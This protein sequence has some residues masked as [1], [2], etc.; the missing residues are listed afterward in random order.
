MSNDKA[1][2][3]PVL[4][5]FLIGCGTI[6]VLVVAIIIWIGVSLFAGSGSS[7]TSPHHPF[8]SAKA[9]EQ[10]LKQYDARAEKWPVTSETLTVH[11]SY[12]QTFVRIS[13]PVGAPP[14]VLLHGAGGSS[15]HW[16]FNVEMLSERFRV[17]V[18]DNICDY[19][20]SVCTQNLTSPDDFVDWLDGLFNGLELRDSIN[21]V[22]MSYG[23][24]MT[25]LYALRFPDRLNK[26]VLLAPAATVL[27][28]RSEWLMHAI[29]CV[30]PHR[31][32]TK[33]FVYWLAE[34]LVHKDEASR[35]MADEW[36]DDSYLA[37]RSFKAKP[38]VKPT[39]LTDEELQSIKV[40]VLFLVGENEK[41]YPAE[42]AVQRLNA[43]APQIETEVI[44]GAGHDLAFVQ[45]EMVNRKILEFLKQP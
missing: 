6:I 9:K 20:R 11:T 34:D 31:Y 19:G 1:K 25:S 7:E 42:K 8:R 41:I 27:P 32:F 24:W 21:L 16:S 22:G 39:V 38:M 44:A 10:Y 3:N 5:F 35:K 17:Y 18:V 37:L 4:K 33:R 28:L 2:K 12:G 15:L 43:V 30:V 13:G 45:A 36:V 14:L 40:P 23:G 26:I 29:L